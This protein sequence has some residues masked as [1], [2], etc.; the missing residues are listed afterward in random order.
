MGINKKFSKS[1]KVK[2]S[3]KGRKVKRSSKGRSRKVKRSSKG[4]SRKVKRSNRFYDGVIGTRIGGGLDDDEQEQ[5]LSLFRRDENSEF[6]YPVSFQKF[7]YK[8]GG[9]L[10]YDIE[11]INN[12]DVRIRYSAEDAIYLFTLN[13][14]G[15][16]VNGLLSRIIEYIL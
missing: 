8:K 2:R 11:E 4:R 14:Q 10:Y 6:S 3:S 16:T 9:V 7:I 13:N 15:I 12:V 1:R 5:F